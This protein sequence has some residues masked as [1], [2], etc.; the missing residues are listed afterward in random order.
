MSE[1]PLKKN[2]FERN[3]KLLYYYLLRS[4]TPFFIIISPE[5]LSWLTHFDTKQKRLPTLKDRIKKKKNPL[6]EFV[7]YSEIQKKFEEVNIIMRGDYYENINTSIPTFFINTYDSK[8]NFPNH[9]YA[10]TDRLMFRAMMGEPENEFLRR[11][12]YDDPD[13]YFYY[14]MPIGPLIENVQLNEESID[15]SV[16]IKK[17]NQ[18]KKILN[19]K[20]EYSLCVCS[21]KY[22]GHNIQIGSGII[23]VISLLKLSKKVNVY[24]WD[25]FLDEKLPKT[26][27][28]QSQKLWS[29]FSEFQP[30]SRFSA[31][32]LNWIYAHRLIN[33]FTSD[34]LIVH[35]KILE[36][37]K[38]DWVEKYLYKMIYR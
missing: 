4:I 7:F 28:K 8:K 23:A 15:P 31:I 33:F 20:P 14:F 16:S 30:V 19:Y 29:D 12:N 9:F 11:F 1:T 21:H 25:S 18:I 36:V 22:K 34:R 24:G 26:Y 13:K 38:L 6:D 37:S 2:F 27:Y 32:V 5:L 10:T 35:G 3:I 17:I